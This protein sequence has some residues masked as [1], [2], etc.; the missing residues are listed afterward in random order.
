MCEVG[1]ELNIA[2]LDLWSAMIARSG[3]SVDEPEP[4]GSIYKPQ[5]ET[6]QS[7]VHDGLHLTAEGYGV[8][9]EEMMA[10][11]ARVWPDQTPEK[12]PFVLPSWEDRRA[13][14]AQTSL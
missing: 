3:G 7:F 11:I 8:M 14:H 2:V 4:I 9:Y 5:N 10:L 12:L 6:L 1:K 13:W